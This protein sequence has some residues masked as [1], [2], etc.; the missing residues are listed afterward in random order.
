[1]FVSDDQGW[2]GETGEARSITTGTP[3]GDPI[4]QEPEADRR[5]YVWDPQGTVL[6]GGPY[7]EVTDFGFFQDEWEPS[8]IFVGDREIWTLH[9]SDIAPGEHILLVGVEDVEWWP[10][11]SIEFCE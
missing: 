9:T 5:M 7:G 1:M 3:I 4:A 2:C 11:A 8:G 10:Q 6:P